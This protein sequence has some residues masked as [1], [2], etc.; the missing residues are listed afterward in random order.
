V[1]VTVFKVTCIAQAVTLRRA[2]WSASFIVGEAEPLRVNVDVN[3][4]MGEV[5]KVGAEVVGLKVGLLVGSPGAG[6]GMNK[7]GLA[8]GR[9]VGSAVG[10]WEG[11]VSSNI[12][13]SLAEAVHKCKGT[14]S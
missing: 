12:S 11:S 6:V 2:S 14:D 3:V 5:W 1:N 10:S 4:M 8:D 7:V 13:K 9:K